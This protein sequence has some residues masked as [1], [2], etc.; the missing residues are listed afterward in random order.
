[1]K[2]APKF[3]NITCNSKIFFSKKNPENTAPTL[4]I[5]HQY[6]F[7]FAVFVTSH[8]GRL[9]GSFVSCFIGIFI[10]ST[11]NFCFREEIQENS[12][13]RQN[14]ASIEYLFLF[15][16][17][18]IS[19]F[20]FTRRYHLTSNLISTLFLFLYLSCYTSVKYR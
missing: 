15:E 17:I 2:I 18:E 20:Q 11:I 19:F 5:R 12:F 9:S 1:M 6:C 16:L 3:F 14:P 8:T 13:V 7:A 10:L 4:Y